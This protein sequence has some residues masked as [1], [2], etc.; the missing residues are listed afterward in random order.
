MTTIPETASLNIIGVIEKAYYNGLKAPIIEMTAY[1]VT[2]SSRSISNTN[3]TSAAMSPLYEYFASKVA[4]ITQRFP[5]RPYLRLR[6]RTFIGH[7][8]AVAARTG[9]VTLDDCQRFALI[10]AD[11]EFAIDVKVLG[12]IIWEV[13]L[14]AAQACSSQTYGPVR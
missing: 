4:S 6:P 10:V 14:R 11:L 8:A 13:S 12:Q 1:E 3:I 7:C 5:R 9:T 2:P